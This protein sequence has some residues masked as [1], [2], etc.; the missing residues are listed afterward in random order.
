M[1]RDREGFAIA[2][3]IRRFDLARDV[4]RGTFYRGRCGIP[5]ALTVR[6]FDLP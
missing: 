5:I 2:V 4:G 6:S 3:P 1:G